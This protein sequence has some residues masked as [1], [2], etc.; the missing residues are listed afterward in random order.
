MDEKENEA[1]DQPDDWEGVE[2]AL[3]E[4]G[5]HAVVVRI[6]FSVLAF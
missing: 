2:D 1:H 3:E 6:Q 4:P 5:E